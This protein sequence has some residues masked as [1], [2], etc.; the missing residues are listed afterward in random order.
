MRKVLLVMGLSIL[1]L[2]ALVVGVVWKFGPGWYAKFA[3]KGEKEYLSK[4]WTEKVTLDDRF[5]IQV[6]FAIPLRPQEQVSQWIKNAAVYQ[7][8]EGRLTVTASVY[9]YVPGVEV[10][11]GQFSEMV[12]ERIRKRKE[13]KNVEFVQTKT[14]VLGVPALE[15]EIDGLANGVPFKSHMIVFNRGTA[16]YMLVL[17]AP[18]TDQI[19]VIWKRMRESIRWV[20]AQESAN[21]PRKSGPVLP[22][23]MKRIE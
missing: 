15:I 10:N 1:L 4:V 22:P 14:Q 7:G 12:F 18:V 3:A 16:G 5:E 6:P 20:G 11:L 13:V 8:R 19:P 9:N 23:G 17:D 21:P 2:I